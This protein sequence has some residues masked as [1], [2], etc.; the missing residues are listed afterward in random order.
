[1]GKHDMNNTM[2]GRE[3]NHV[4]NAEASTKKSHS[5]YAGEFPTLRI[6]GPGRNVYT[7]FKPGYGSDKVA[8]TIREPLTNLRHRLMSGHACANQSNQT[9]NTHYTWPGG[10]YAEHHNGS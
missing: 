3:E 2:T 7:T 6:D 10:Q 4:G 1:M 5:I 8:R 9:H